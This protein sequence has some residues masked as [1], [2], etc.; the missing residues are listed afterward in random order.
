MRKEEEVND[1]GR[2][3]YFLNWDNEFSVRF[4]IHDKQIN[5]QHVPKNIF[6]VELP[7]ISVSDLL[8]NDVDW[9][10]K[11]T[12]R[13]TTDG[14]VESE[15]F[16]TLLRNSFDIEL[17]LKN[18]N[19]VVWKYND[20]SVEKIGFSPLIDR[21][22]RSNPFNYIL[23]IKI[24]QAIYNGNNQIIEFGIPEQVTAKTVEEEGEKE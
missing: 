1:K 11:L 12:L 24:R 19:I 18:P 14:L 6:S 15:V 5:V 13:S 16:N 9:I 20:C 3:L 4:N 2:P 8:V 10:L 22:S 7:E 23:Y 21:K 17:S